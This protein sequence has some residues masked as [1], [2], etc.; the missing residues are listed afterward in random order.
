MNSVSQPEKEGKWQTAARERNCYCGLWDTNPAMY[1]ERGYPLGFCGKCERCGAPGHTRHFP[2]P[3]PYTGAWC[4]RCYRIVAWTSPFRA[5]KGWAYLIVF[6]FVAYEV[7]P[8][9][10]RALMR[11][12]NGN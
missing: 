6:G 2:G 10:I 8:S 3:V 11:A 4:D 9:L 7:A 5:G 12:L 1:E